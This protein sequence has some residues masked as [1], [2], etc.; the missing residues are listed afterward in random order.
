MWQESKGWLG[1]IKFAMPVMPLSVDSQQT[2][3]DMNLELGAE[4]RA[5]D[6]NL[7]VS[8]HLRNGILSHGPE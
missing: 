2:L 5:T 1:R 4:V 7:R 8:H 6:V 3:G